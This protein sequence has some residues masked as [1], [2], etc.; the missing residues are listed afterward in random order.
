MVSRQQ[1]SGP[2]LSKG[3]APRKLNGTTHEAFNLATINGARAVKMATLIGSI[4]LGKKA[5]LVVIDGTSPGMVA[6]YEMDPVTAVVRHSDSADCHWVIINGKIRKSDGKLVPIKKVD[7]E[8]NGDGKSM[9]WPE[10]RHELVRSRAEIQKRIEKLNMPKAE[11]LF[12][13][14]FYIQEENLI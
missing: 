7:Y 12:K 4:A 6:A 3:K 13:Q 5:D 1:V 11:E 10:I 8:G 9:E 14:I 2:I